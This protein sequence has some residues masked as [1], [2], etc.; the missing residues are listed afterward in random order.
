MNPSSLIFVLVVFVMAVYF[1]GVWHE[2]SQSK[3]DF[4]DWDSA[5]SACCVDRPA[6]F[7]A[8]EVH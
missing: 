1:D 4:D 5:C 7:D 3:F 6:G 8:T 2:H